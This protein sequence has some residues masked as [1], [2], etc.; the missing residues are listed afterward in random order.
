MDIFFSRNICIKTEGVIMIMKNTM[1]EKVPRFY[2]EVFEAWGKYRV[3]IKYESNKLSQIINQPV[4]CNP[5][6]TKNNNMLWEKK[7]FYAG[8]RQ[9]KDYIYKFIPGF[10]R[11]QAIIDT[12]QEYD[13]DMSESSIVNIYDKIKESIPMEGVR[14]IENNA[15]TDR[16]ITFP[17]LYTENN[18]RKIVLC[19]LNVKDYYKMLIREELKEPASEKVLEKVFPGMKGNE[20]WK[21]W[22]VKK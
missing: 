5:I 22:I 12:V 8:L 17:E 3:N 2:K 13:E 11:N 15:V 7:I 19:N 14:Q 1:Y 9:I 10:L 20:I 4:W 16:K 21:N 6:I 18:G